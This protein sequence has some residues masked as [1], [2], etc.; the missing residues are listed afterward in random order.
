MKQHIIFLCILLLGCSKNNFSE[1]PVLPNNPDVDKVITINT[2][3]THQTIEGF[4]ASDCWSVNYVGKHW[5]INQ[6]ESITK[7]LFSKEIKDGNPQGIGLSMW[8][9][10]L[11]AGTAEQG[12]Q[13]GIEDKSRRTE[14]FLNSDGT[15]DWT[16]QQ[17]QQ[18]FLEKAKTYGCESFV[19]FS[20]SPPVHYTYNGKGFSA[21]KA[22]SNLKEE[23]YDDFANYMTEV[24]KYFQKNKNIHFNYISP[25]NEPQFNWEK[26]QEGSGWQNSEIKKLVTHLNKSL[27]D[28][29]L[30]SKILITE[31]ADW[32][33]LFKTKDDAARSNQIEDFFSVQ[34]QNY[35]GNLSRMA[36]LIGGHSYWTDGNSNALA[37]ARKQLF[38][39]ANSYGL[40]IFQTEWSM[41]GDHYNDR[42]YPGHDS[43]NSLDIA[44]YMSKVLYY[45]LTVA[46]VSSWSFW[47]SI[48]V[49]RWNHKNRFLLINLT[50]AGGEYGDI[51]QSG[52]HQAT[53]S[54]WVLG[55][56]SLFIRPNY[57][58]VEMNIDGTSNSFFGSAWISPEKN[59]LVVVFTN[60]TSKT[61]TINPQIQGLGKY[62]LLKKYTTSSAKNLKEE[63]SSEGKCTI[64]PK[65]VTTLVYEY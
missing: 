41:L 58:R 51:S 16:K 19:M 11:G 33:Y 2:A 46:N 55:N 53:K 27:E 61:I 22:Y 40:K 59:K 47:T 49:A 35:V 29:N 17:G 39:A 60:M 45:D 48:D 24:A 32:E 30:D 28:K 15:Y 42:D 5:D 31:A 6:K 8:R 57:K 20:N 9:L 50:P 23:H 12:D 7:L 14:C 26:G 62:K 65:S 64:E 37:N 36:P 13:S 63:I 3:T 43:A 1:T 44:L 21:R 4:G 25:V 52:T 54:L 10:N 18:Y 56:Y 34:S 38:S